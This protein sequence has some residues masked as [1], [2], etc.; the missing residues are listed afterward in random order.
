MK[1]INWKKE[2][3]YINVYSDYEI[4][5]TK[6][7]VKEYIENIIAINGISYLYCNEKRLL[8]YLKIKS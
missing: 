1:K 7:G 4:K 5:E 3:Q 6:S 2:A 8:K